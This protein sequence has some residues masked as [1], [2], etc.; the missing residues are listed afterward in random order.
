MELGESIENAAARETLEEA[1]ADVEITT[2]FALYT[3]RRVDQVYVVFRGSCEPR[4]LVS[5]MKALRWNSY[6]LR[7]SLGISWHFP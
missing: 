4:T 3:L 5:E 6:P 1:K 2:L 7:T